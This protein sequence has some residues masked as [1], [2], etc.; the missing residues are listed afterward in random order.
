MFFL[1]SHSGNKDGFFFFSVKIKL[2]DQTIRQVELRHV[3]LTACSSENTLKRHLVQSLV[4]LV[5]R[6]M[7]WK[8]TGG[9]WGEETGTSSSG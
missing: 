1:N 9:R 3:F 2:P 7:G 8:E 5:V 4:D 6:V